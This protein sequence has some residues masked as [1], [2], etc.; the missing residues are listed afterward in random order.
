MVLAYSAQHPIPRL[1]TFAAPY[2]SKTVI[3]TAM[4][5]QDK[6]RIKNRLEGALNFDLTPVLPMVRNVFVAHGERDELVPIGHARH[7]HALAKAPKTLYIQ[8]GGDHRMSN[9][10][11][12]Q[13]FSERFADWMTSVKGVEGMP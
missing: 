2:T 9:P 8:A 4:H 7:I 10:V 5:S 13:A 12:Q 11:H 6:E 3:N 1:A